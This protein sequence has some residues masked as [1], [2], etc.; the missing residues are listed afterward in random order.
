MHKKEKEILAILGLL[1][2]IAFWGASMYYTFSSSVNILSGEQTVSSPKP[3]PVVTTAPP[4]EAELKI[5]R[6]ARSYADKVVDA[7]VI[8]NN[9]EFIYH[10]FGKDIKEK[11]F[12]SDLQK[13][14][15]DLKVLFGNLGIA[16]SF[17]YTNQAFPTTNKEMITCY[18]SIIYKRDSYEIHTVIQVFLK[19]SDNNFTLNGLQQ[20]PI[21]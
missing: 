16:N 3:L 13:C 7:L 10:C 18:Y 17:S 1:L 19:V 5:M 20:Q 2:S 15:D 6:E 21:S 9:Y 14:K 11:F 8:K 4:T 12:K